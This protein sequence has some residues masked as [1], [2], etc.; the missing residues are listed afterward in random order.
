MNKIQKY[1]LA[2]L[3]LQVI[4]ILVVFILQRPVSASNN[5]LFPDLK[6][7]AVTAITISDST[8][9]SVSLEKQ[10]DQWILPLQDEFPVKPD[11]VQQLV[12]QLATIRD[13]RLV[14]RD[15][16]SHERLHISNDNFER[17]VELT[18]N[19]SKQV[20]YFG[21]SP[22]TSNIHFRLDD[23]SE[24]YLTNALT[25]TQLSTAISSWV[26]PILFLIPSS[27]V[28]KIQISN[29]AGTFP[30]EPDADSVWSSQFLEEGF[31]FDQSK[32]SSLFSGF[33]NLRF[34]EPVSKSE[35]AAYGFEKPQA[36]MQIEYSNENGETKLGELVIGGQD[37][38]GNYYAK[39]TDSVYI[40]LISSN[41][42]ER[43]VNLTADD[44]SSSIATEESS[45][46]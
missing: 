37:E 22:A 6:V 24:V 32:W 7:E 30:F 35:K 11:T 1:L 20:I 34:V 23:K 2:A 26:D 18:L 31:Q 27:A 46:E 40:T 29:N 8:G 10:G 33:T 16:A 21:S 36:T 39:W 19:G 3:G 9:K 15:E 5:L 12:E 41:N 43:F 38:A 42:A 17:K 13:N 4:L 14:T 44:Y 28:N 45:N 25:T